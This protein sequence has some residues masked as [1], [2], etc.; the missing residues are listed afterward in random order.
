M[1]KACGRHP[2]LVFTLF[3]LRPEGD[4]IATW[5]SKLTA[6]SCAS[7]SASH[8]SPSFPLILFAWGF[9]I[10]M[11]VGWA[12]EYNYQDD[13][14]KGWYY[15]FLGSPLTH[16]NCLQLGP[17]LPFSCGCQTVESYIFTILLVYLTN[18]T[19][20]SILNIFISTY[21]SIWF[22]MY[23]K[24]FMYHIMYTKYLIY[25]LFNIIKVLPRVQSLKILNTSHPSPFCYEFW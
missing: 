21:T 2:S 19:H 23:K 20:S 4:P 12:E 25:L 10:I 11:S 6:L 22:F 17:E 13:Q 9:L 5:K 14:E 18:Q 15:P 16:M 1:G 8:L 3:S 7:H 24:E